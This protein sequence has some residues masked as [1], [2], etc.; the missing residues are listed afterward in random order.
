[1][2]LLVGCTSTTSVLPVRLSSLFDAKGPPPIR[3]TVDARLATELAPDAKILEGLDDDVRPLVDRVEFLGY[4]A[5]KDSVERFAVINDVVAV[6]QVVTIPE[7]IVA[8]PGEL[9]RTGRVSA[10]PVGSSSSAVVE[11]LG[12]PAAYRRDEAGSELFHF[13]EGEDLILAFAIEQKVWSVFTLRIDP[14]LDAAYRDDFA[15]IIM[16]A[17][18][19]AGAGLDL[20]PSRKHVMHMLRAE[21]R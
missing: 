21:R 2:F 12:T 1:V 9:G 10:T 5:G 15:S 3:F 13:D 4:Y 7:L 14:S 6:R 18:V 8:E 19:G 17:F 16:E 11:L 20:G